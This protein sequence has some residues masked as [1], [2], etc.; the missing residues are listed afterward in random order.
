MTDAQR[1]VAITQGINV[2][3][4]KLALI[5]VPHPDRVA[6]TPSTK[7]PTA[8]NLTTAGVLLIVYLP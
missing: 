5:T 3:G 6:G 8:A 7:P 2:E 1:R 4:V